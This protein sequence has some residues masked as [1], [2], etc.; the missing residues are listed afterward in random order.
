MDTISYHK[1]ESEMYF[2]DGILSFLKA[3]RA[4][5]LFAILLYI[6][7]LAFEYILRKPVEFTGDYDILNE[8]CSEMKKIHDKFSKVVPMIS[9]VKNPFI[10]ERFKN[11]FYCYEEFLENI[12]DGFAISADR[13]AR[14]SVEKLPV[15]LKNV[16]EN[17]PTL[18]D[19][20]K[21]L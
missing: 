2:I 4:K 7:I 6:L 20:F 19:M 14:E 17:L 16:S 8:Q 5:L 1:I 12:V 18:D 3:T 9:S 21:T 11:R 13:E 15:I 10:P